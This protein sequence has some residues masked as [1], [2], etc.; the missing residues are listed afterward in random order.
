MRR[1]MASYR[2]SQRQLAIRRLGGKCAQCGSTKDLQFD[3]RDPATKMDTIAN[4]SELRSWRFEIELLKCQ[5]LCIECHKKKTLTDLGQ[6]G[7]AVHGS[8]AAYKVC[9]PP[10]CE[11][12]RAYKRDAMARLRAQRRKSVN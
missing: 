3:H 2:R 4:L 11:E 7:R 9:G 1:Y 6:L 8:A 12:C 10:K 5:L